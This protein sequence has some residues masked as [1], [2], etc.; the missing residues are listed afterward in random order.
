M[1][2][3][4]I[5]HI[6]VFQVKQIIPPRYMSLKATLWYTSWLIR[7]E[8]EVCGSNISFLKHHL[9]QELSSRAD[10]EFGFDHQ[11]SRLTIPCIEHYFLDLIF[12]LDQVLTLSR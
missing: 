8:E 7:R 12:L 1:T 9:F 4:I 2:I 10:E 6:V 5:P 11:M 3:H